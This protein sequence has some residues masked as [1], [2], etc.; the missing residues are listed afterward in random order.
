MEPNPDWW[1]H[2]A[3]D[4]RGAVTINNIT[5]AVRAESEVRT[6][7][8]QRNEAD[9]GRWVGQEQCKRAPQCRGGPIVETIVIRP[10][11]MN[12]ALAARRLRGVNVRA[13]C[14]NQL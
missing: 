5:F 14:S 7:M 10:D 6:A 12:P 9:V 8:V 3:A 11:T 13:E 2:T 4:A 1:G